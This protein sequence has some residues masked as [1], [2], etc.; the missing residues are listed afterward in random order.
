MKNALAYFVKSSI[1]KKYWLFPLVFK[2]TNMC[3][4]EWNFLAKSR[5]QWR[6]I[7]LI[8]PRLSVQIQQPTTPLILGGKEMLWKDELNCFLDVLSSVS[9]FL[10]SFSNERSNYFPPPLFLYFCANSGIWA[11]TLHIRMRSWVLYL[12]TTTKSSLWFILWSTD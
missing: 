3:H 2:N 5:A 12:C 6:I 11:W 1:T 10:N 4:Y 8:I 9:Y 7:H